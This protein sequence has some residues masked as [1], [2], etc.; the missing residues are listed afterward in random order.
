M[1]AIILAGGEGTRLRP[2][3][4]DRPKPMLNIMGA[5]IMEHCIKLLKKHAITEIAVTEGYMAGKIREFFGD[6]TALGVR[7]TYFNED[8]PLGTA[9]ALK[10][11]WDFVDGDFVAMSG[12]VITDMD[13]TSLIRFHKSR[14]ALASIALAPASPYPHRAT[15]TIGEGGRIN[16]LFESTDWGLVASSYISCGVGVLSPKLLTLIPEGIFTDLIRDIFPVLLNDKRGI[17]GM[18]HG[19]YW[20][21]IGSLGDYRRCH[22]D[23]LDRKTALNMPE[24]YSEGIWVESGAE[25]QQGAVLRPPA[26]IGGRSRILRGSRVE[27]YSVIGRGV[28]LCAGSGIKRGIALDGCRLEENA[29]LRGAVIDREAVLKRGSAV[30]EQAVIGSGSVVG[31]NCAVKPGVRIWPHKELPPD[32]VQHSNLIWGSVGGGRIWSS[33]GVQGELGS[34]I[35]PETMTLL[36]AAFGTAADGCGVGVSDSGSPAAAMLKSAFIGGVLSTGAKIFDFGEQPLPVSRSGVRFHRLWGGAAVNVYTRGGADYGE[37]KLIGPNGAD[38]QSELMNRLKSSFRLEDFSRGSSENIKDAEYLFEYK[39]FYLK[40]LINSTKKQ[41]LGY[42]LLVGGS[43]D[44]AKRLLKSA[45]N[46][47]NCHVETSDKGPHEIAQAVKEEGADLGAVIDPSC[48]ELTLIDISGRII[49]RDIYTL[50]SAM[51]VMHTHR[52]A[53]I[54]VP[55]S[56]PSGVELLAEKYGAVVVRTRNS[57]PELMRELTKSDDPMLYDQFIYAFDAVGALIKLIDFMK[58][59]NASLSE[60]LARLPETHMIHTGVDCAETSQAMNKIYS[61]HQSQPMD[62]TDG[63]KL[64]FDKGWVLLTP[65]EGFSSINITSQG[66]CEEYARELADMCV[67]EILED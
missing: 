63:I 31:E 66:Y 61:R 14:K 67:D 6:G 52:G 30:Y 15:M 37:I 50:L 54:Y 1:K 28:T 11:A 40:N 10:N 19:G 55:I 4:C 44:W 16:R 57:P 58:S 65:S 5:P 9:G 20:C 41:S 8:T 18:P 53:K 38:P 25:I 33:A 7:L 2:L 51:I 60:L 32:T 22:G 39:L 45:G 56:A 23:I 48:Q 13:I 24:E 43:S 26:F 12:S 3:T 62:L 59:E 49:S 27:P 47:L 64:S 35:T 36:G 29:Q 42:K 46:D 17:Y 34:E 21:N